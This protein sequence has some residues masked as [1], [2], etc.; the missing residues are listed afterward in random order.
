MT[1]RIA[2]I[3]NE[4]FNYLGDDRWDLAEILIDFCIVG[5]EFSDLH[6]KELL[7]KLVAEM[8]EPDNFTI[9]DL[10][11]E[12]AKVGTEYAVGIS[13]DLHDMEAF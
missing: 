4:L 1:T 11:E 2:A 5:A 3:L 9:D 7:T 6:T 8:P 10:A 12:I 13:K